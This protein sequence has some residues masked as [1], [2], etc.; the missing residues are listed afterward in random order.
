MRVRAHRDR[1]AGGVDK[2]RI[3][4]AA[5]TAG[6]THRNANTNRCSIGDRQRGRAG[7]AAITATAANRLRQQTGRVIAARLNRIGRVD[8]DRISITA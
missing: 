7:P 6:T 4:I 1:V 2:N 3:A 5:A 8:D